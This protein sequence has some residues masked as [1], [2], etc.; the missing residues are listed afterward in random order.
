MRNTEK[1]KRSYAAVE[2]AKL[3]Y[4]GLGYIANVLCCDPKT[5][6]QSRQDL[7]NRPELGVGKVMRAGGGRKK[8]IRL[9]NGLEQAFF[10]VLDDYT[11]GYGGR[12]NA[13]AGT[14]DESEPA[15]N[16]KQS[17]RTRLPGQ[18]QYCPAATQEAPLHETQGAKSVGD[19]RAQRSQTG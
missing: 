8:L 5:I 3:G 18:P 7:D 9:E 15:G 19:G 16:C 12:A 2:A 6:Q 11:A 14:L 13:R 17:G 4:G 10:V 1:D